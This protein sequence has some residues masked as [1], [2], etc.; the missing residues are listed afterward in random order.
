MEKNEAGK[1]K[2]KVKDHL[3]RFSF[4]GRPTYTYIGAHARIVTKKKQ[5][6][7]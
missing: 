3:T 1:I 2:Q 7:I 6:N 4:S 5:K